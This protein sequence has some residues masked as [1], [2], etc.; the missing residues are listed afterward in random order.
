MCHTFTQQTPSSLTLQCDLNECNELVYLFSPES[1]KLAPSS[2]TS[3]CWSS[4]MTRT[5]WSCWGGP[6]TSSTSTASARTRTRTLRSQ[7]AASA[8]SHHIS[9]ESTN[10]S[11]VMHHHRS[12][13]ILFG[14]AKSLFCWCSLSL[15]SS[16]GWTVSFRLADIQSCSM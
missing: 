1:S 14:R 15:R 7:S 2:V 11:L 6:A 9:T 16:T 13:C 12:A 5:S 10:D 8:P 4:P 3:S